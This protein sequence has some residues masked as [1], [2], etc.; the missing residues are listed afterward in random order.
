MRKSLYSTC[1]SNLWQNTPMNVV[2]FHSI[3]TPPGWL[4]WLVAYP[5]Q[6]IF[7]EILLFLSL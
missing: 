2:S 7:T 1:Y 3:A 6:Q 4:R 5:Q